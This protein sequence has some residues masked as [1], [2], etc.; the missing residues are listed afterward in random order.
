MPHQEVEQV[1]G[2]RRIHQRCLVIILVGRVIEDVEHV[3]DR[4]H[5]GDGKAVVY[6]GGQVEGGIHQEHLTGSHITEGCCQVIPGEAASLVVD[7]ISRGCPADIVY[8]PGELIHQRH[9]AQGDRPCIGKADGEGD[10]AIDDA[11]RHNP[12]AQGYPGI[13]NRIGHRSRG[14]RRYFG[15]RDGGRIDDVFHP[16]R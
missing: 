14:W 16:G 5:V 2:C 15:A 10:H 3:A 12:F 11:G 13:D 7:R 9:H 1:Y 4:G 8:G 6:G